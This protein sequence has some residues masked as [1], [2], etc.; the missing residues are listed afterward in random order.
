LNSPLKWSST[1]C[2]S[3]FVIP[4]FRCVD[5]HSLDEKTIDNADGVIACCRCQSKVEMLSG[6]PG[7]DEPVH[8]IQVSDAIVKL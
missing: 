4:L 3:L 7:L 6:Y 8:D 1:S 5:I 2:N